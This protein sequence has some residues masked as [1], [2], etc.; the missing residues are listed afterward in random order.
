METTTL[1]AMAIA[2][3]SAGGIATFL[4]AVLLP[5]SVQECAR[6]NGRF[7]GLEACA[8]DSGRD[9]G[10]RIGNPEAA[11]GYGKLQLR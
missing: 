1:I 7:V 4:I 6:N 2:L 9:A 11:V 10:K 3:V 8:T 5:R